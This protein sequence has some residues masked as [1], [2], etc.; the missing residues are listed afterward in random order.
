MTKNQIEK[1]IYTTCPYTGLEN[2]WSER[3]YESG[4]WKGVSS[5]DGSSITSDS[6]E[7]LRLRYEKTLTACLIA[8]EN[9]K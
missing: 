3:E 4:K 5:V 6:W 9:G 8:K 7:G 2:C 1:K